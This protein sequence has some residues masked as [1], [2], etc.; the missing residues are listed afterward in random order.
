MQSQAIDMSGAAATATM[1]LPAIYQQQLFAGNLQ[2]QP[3]A[4]G[5]LTAVIPTSAMTTAGGIR[6]PQSIQIQQGQSLSHQQILR[7]QL[8]PQNLSTKVQGQVDGADDTEGEVCNTQI[9]APQ[10]LQETD[11]RPKTT[12]PKKKIPKKKVREIEVVLQLDGADTS[13]D[14][15]DDIDDD[16]DDDVDNEGGDGEGEEEP[17][18]SEDDDE[19]AEDSSTLFEMDNVIVC[20]YDKVGPH[21]RVL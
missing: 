21:Q 18:N 17:L 9:N 13:S 16:V 12:I 5:G 15:D 6:L 8:Q 11:C 19:D 2:L 20:Q 1:A 14:E 7:P 4:I 3:N 10:Q